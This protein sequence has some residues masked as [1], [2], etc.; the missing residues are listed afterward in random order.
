MVRNFNSSCCGLH[1]LTQYAVHLATLMVR[2]L[3]EVVAIAFANRMCAVTVAIS[4]L[5]TRTDLTT[6]LL[7]VFRAKTVLQQLVIA[8]NSQ[9]L[10]FAWRVL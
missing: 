5:K 6:L 9:E 4:V 1:H 2:T 7:I 10:A 8:V 3:T